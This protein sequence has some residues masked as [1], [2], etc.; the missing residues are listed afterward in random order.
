M[1]SPRN[2]VGAAKDVE[3]VPRDVSTDQINLAAI[4]EGQA[5]MQ[6]EFTKYKKRSAEK[7]DTLKTRELSLEKEDRNGC[8]SERQGEGDSCGVQN[9]PPSSH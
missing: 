1:V 4:L 5:K 8:C 6:Q 7:M 3:L 2:K 9:S